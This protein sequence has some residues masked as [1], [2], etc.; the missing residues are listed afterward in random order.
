VPILELRQDGTRY[1]DVHHSPNDTVDKIDPPTLARAAA[2]FATAVW[3]AAD[4]DGDFGRVPVE[5]RKVP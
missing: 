1:F 2:A 3:A 4:A 5:K